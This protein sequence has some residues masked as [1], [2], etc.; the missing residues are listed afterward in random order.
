[1]S[2]KPYIEQSGLLSTSAFLDL[3]EVSGDARQKLEDEHR[4]ESVTLRHPA[5]RNCVDP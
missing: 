2:V 4:A 1:M 3:F 5:P